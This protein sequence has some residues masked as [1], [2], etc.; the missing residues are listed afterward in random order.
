MDFQ[1][2]Q[3]FFLRVGGAVFFSVYGDTVRNAAKHKCVAADVFLRLVF[4]L[5]KGFSCLRLA[6]AFRS[7]LSLLW[8]VPAS[9]LSL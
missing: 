8:T 2:T 7:S 5:L 4:Y 1:Q 6:A 3:Q 9:R